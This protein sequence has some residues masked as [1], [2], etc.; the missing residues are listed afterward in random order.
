MKGH[1]VWFPAAVA[2]L[3]AAAPDVSAQA[4][5]HVPASFPTIQSAIAAALGGD[6]VLVAPGTYPESVDFLG[7]AI[8]VRAAPG[9]AASTV[10]QGTPA[11]AV[12]TFHG[13]EPPTAVLDGFTIRG[14]FR[15]VDCVNASPT[16]VNCLI[17]AN[18]APWDRGAGVRIRAEAGGSAL[19]RIDTCRILANTAGYS[20]GGIDISCALA[21]CSVVVADTIVEGNAATSGSGGGIAV[22]VA[23]GGG[24]AAIGLED[25]LLKGNQASSSGG[26]LY[27]ESASS[28][29]LTRCVARGNVA[30][31]GAGGYVW[32]PSS[33]QFLNCLITGNT[34]VNQG[35][36]LLLY[37]PGGGLAML[38]NCTIASNSAP[39]VGGVHGLVFSGA[40][41]VHNSIVWGNQNWDVAVA[42]PSYIVDHSDIGFGP[43]NGAGNI[44]AD[45]LFVDAASGDWHLSAMSPCRDAGTGAVLLLSPADLDGTP[46]Q[47]GAAIDMG[48]DEIP[49]LSWPGTMDDLDIFVT[50]SA[51]TDP[52]ASIITAPAGMDVAARLLSPGGAF[53][54][55]PYVL[56]AVVFAT[57]SPPPPSPVPG[58]H[59]GLAPQLLTPVPGSTPFTTPGLPSSGF[60]LGF[61]TPPGLAGISV[62]VQA[63]AISAAA[64]NGS[65]AASGA[66]E[67]VFP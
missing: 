47:Q 14:G 63:V 64:L 53:A 41:L 24:Y 2:V 34:A 36:G 18:S 21:Y 31:S 7:K 58:L 20:G 28:V 17:T 27:A 49:A 6:T 22:I 54:G 25:V 38:T 3:V 39:V 16:I 45:P 10:I 62:R 48:C 8:A 52:L 42:N 29:N 11:A 66:R 19:P 33:S 1:P 4:T 43:A 50:T 65:W 59:L 57:A 23:G 40:L 44:A 61:T 67:I 60:A 37:S 32:G 55:A 5:L 30:N 46:R 51:T 56:A 26:G 12:V 35:G 15:G 13:A 9:A